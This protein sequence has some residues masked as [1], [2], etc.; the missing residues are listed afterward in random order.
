MTETRCQAAAGTAPLAD[1]GPDTV[2][3]QPMVVRSGRFG[4]YVTDGE[5][6]ASLPKGTDPATLTLAAANDL[7]EARR[8]APPRPGRGRVA[9][10]GKKKAAGETTAKA[11]TAKP[12]AT[13]AKAKAKPGA[14]KSRKVAA[15]S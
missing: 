12:K 11:K 15:S 9:S 3:G 5:T 14:K 10:R 1:L 4:P 13:K 7:L 2:S 8:S 6:N